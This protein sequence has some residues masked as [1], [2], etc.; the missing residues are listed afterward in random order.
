[1]TIKHESIHITISPRFYTTLGRPRPPR[2]H[3]V[4][5]IK[6]YGDTNCCESTYHGYH[7]TRSKNHVGDHITAAFGGDIVSWWEN[8]T[9]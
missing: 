9:E 6:I 4:N 1:M 8:V 2:H 3:M 7:C 5:A